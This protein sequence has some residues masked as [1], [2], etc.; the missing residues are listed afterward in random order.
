MENQTIWDVD[1]QSESF[2]AQLEAQNRIKANRLEDVRSV[3]VVFSSKAVVF[4]KEALKQKIIWAYPEAK[5]YFMNPVGK[6]IGEKPP[7]RVDLV[8]DF[9][10]P[11]QHGAWFL[12][13]RMS[14]IGRVTVGRNAGLFRKGDYDRIVDE[15]AKGAK[16]PKDLLD[17]ERYVQKEVL[18]LAGIPLAQMGEPPPDFGQSIALKLPRLA[19]SKN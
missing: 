6:P 5:I 10:S 15:K 19:K 18:S 7:S 2:L 16:L 11:R 12:S 14:R 3:L 1:P 9:T 4:D 13:K 8:L 17:R